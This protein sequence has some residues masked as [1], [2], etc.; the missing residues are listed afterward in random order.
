MDKQPPTYTESP[1]PPAHKPEWKVIIDLLRETNPILLNRIGR[2]MMNYLVKRNVK[3]VDRLVEKL[4]ASRESLQV[5][6][7]TIPTNRCPAS[8]RPCWRHIIEDIFQIAADEIDRRRDH[9]DRQPVAQAGAVPLPGH[10]R[11]KARRPAGRDLRRRASLLHDGRRAEEPL[12]R[13]EPG[14][15]RGPDPALLQRGPG[16]HQHHQEVRHV[17]PDFAGAAVQAP[18]GPPGATASWAARPPACSGPRRS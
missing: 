3:Q 13:G 6:L 16:L 8:T 10:G 18:S 7:P 5:S 17:C 15:P 4:T 1:A 9:P 2:K 11:R 14:H 12:A